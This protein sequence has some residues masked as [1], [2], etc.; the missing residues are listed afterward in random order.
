MKILQN[1]WN[2]LKQAIRYGLLIEIILLAANF[3]LIERVIRG[4]AHYFRPKPI[5]ADSV[6]RWWS[7]GSNWL[8][9]RGRGRLGYYVQNHHPR[10]Y[11]RIPRL[12]QWRK[13]GEVNESSAVYWLG[14]S[15]ARARII[16]DCP[17]HPPVFVPPSWPKAL[18]DI[19]RN[20]SNPHF[21]EDR[22]T[23]ESY[24]FAFSPGHCSWWAVANSYGSLPGPETVKWLGRRLIMRWFLF[25]SDNLWGK[26]SWA[27]S[28]NLSFSS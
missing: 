4:I 26:S 21:M 8:L 20:C 16:V 9:S 12:F 17:R 14:P 3:W 15:R 27:F 18:V 11:Q 10:V 23:L 24:L 25:I 19:P 13:E 22:S 2:V 6:I 5:G 7:L 28:S 1:I